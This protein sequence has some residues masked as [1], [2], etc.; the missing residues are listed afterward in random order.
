MT[1]W[2]GWRQRGTGDGKGQEQKDVFAVQDFKSWEAHAGLFKRRLNKLQ[3][4]CKHIVNV[5]DIYAILFQEV[6]MGNWKTSS[7]L[8]SLNILNY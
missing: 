7:P 4:L 2:R 6:G 3:C 8:R 1:N 5:S